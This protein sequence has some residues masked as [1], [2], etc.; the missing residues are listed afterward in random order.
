MKFSDY[1]KANKDK[2]AGADD[3]SSFDKQ[4][5]FS[6]FKKFEGKS[7]DEIVSLILKTA[8]NRRAEGTLS[9]REIDDFYNTIYPVLDEKKRE[10]LDKI[11]ALIKSQKG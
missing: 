7:E 2:Y 8:E 10:K 3:F 4:K 9:D 11:V 6:L 1:D 5:L